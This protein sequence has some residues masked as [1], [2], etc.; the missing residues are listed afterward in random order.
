MEGLIAY[1]KIF[2]LVLFFSF[3]CGVFIWTYRSGNSEKME[4]MRNIPFKED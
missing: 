2:A 1:T 4:G 3:Y